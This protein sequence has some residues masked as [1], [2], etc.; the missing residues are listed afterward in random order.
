MEWSTTVVPT[1]P[2]GGSHAL[3][4][5]QH[6]HQVVRVGRFVSGCQRLKP[7][8]NTLL[9]TAPADSAETFT[10][11][12]CAAGGGP[13]VH[14]CAV[15]FRVMGI[16]WAKP[17]IRSCCATARQRSKHIRDPPWDASPG[18]LPRLA[19]GRLGVIMFFSAYR[20][21]SFAPEDPPSHAYLRIKSPPES[22]A[23]V[24]RGVKQVLCLY[25]Y[26]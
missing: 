22:V 6:H 15:F 18:S 9:A 16:N 24:K 25:I 8:K 3:Q 23:K 19:A 13:S 5:C 1:Y 17:C 7:S 26:K 12:Q 14:A 11:R 4:V 2:E 10:V 21:P 20:L